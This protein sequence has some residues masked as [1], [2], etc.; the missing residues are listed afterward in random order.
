VSQKGSPANKLVPY[1]ISV[2]NQ[3]AVKLFI[4]VRAEEDGPPNF[5]AMASRWNKES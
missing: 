1:K 3:R 2:D 4:E 5:K